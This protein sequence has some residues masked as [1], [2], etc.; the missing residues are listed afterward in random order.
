M[1]PT[2]VIQ[3]AFL[4]D[5]VLTT[6]LLAVLAE[7]FGPVDVVTTPGAAM[8]LETHS[9][10]RQ[11]IRYDKRGADRGFGGLF[12][13]AGRLRKERYARVYLP[14]RSLRSAALARVARIDERIGY[15]GAPGAWSYTRRIPRPGTGHEAERILALAE[16]PPGARAKVS[17]DLTAEDR[18]K[19]GA[20][21]TTHNVGTPFVAMAPGSIWGTKRWPGY[22]ELARVLDLPVVAVGGPED[23]DLSA[24]IVAAA[25][26]RAHSAAGELSL[27]ESAAL[28]E[29]AAVLVTNDSAPL[30]LATA[31]GTPVVAIFGP[32]VP[33]FGFGPR[34]P[35]DRIV[36]LVGLSCRPCSSHGPRVCPLGHHRCMRELSVATVVREIAS[37][38]L[39]PRDD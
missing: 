6:G 5:V 10:V 2:L 38:S 33:A 16:P 8:L 34:G 39:A 37:G 4:G 13:L 24:A 31:V 14:H 26:G 19:A 17:L 30:H 36:E 9:A 27:R 25:P 3:T 18:Q 32:T 7:R 29:R 23:R 21:L 35:K 1:S 12:R 28:L 11:V 20:W 22:G 15:T